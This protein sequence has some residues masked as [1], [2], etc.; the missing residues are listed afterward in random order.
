MCTISES[1]I[2]IIIFLVNLLTIRAN[3]NGS[4]A[5]QTLECIEPKSFQKDSNNAQR[6]AVQIKS[7]ANVSVNP[8][9]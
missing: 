1:I 5:M 4:D 3:I 8:L 7:K 9:E 2:I 6:P